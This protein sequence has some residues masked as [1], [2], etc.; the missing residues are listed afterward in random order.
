MHINWT[1][2]RPRQG[3]PGLWDRFVGPGATVAE[4][5]VQ[6]VGATGMAIALL[7]FTLRAS[8]GSWQPLQVVLLALLAFDVSGGIITNATSTAKRWYHR[9]GRTAWQHLLFVLPHGAHLAL[10]LWIAPGLGWW[11]GVVSYLYLIVATVVVL[12]AP[13]Y[14]RRPLALIA[15]AGALLL[16]AA[17]A[18]P[19][20]LTWFVPFLFLKL[21]VAHLLK[22]APFR[23]ANE[24]NR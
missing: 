21:L 3:W 6:L 22:E 7:V 1:P 9:E 20:E 16:N 15:Y 17:L 14:L 23:P 13:L 19:H 18:P 12:C 24:Q 8:P 2:P 11:L 4:L 10:L 5:Y